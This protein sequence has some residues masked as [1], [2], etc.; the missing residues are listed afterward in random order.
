M[1]R[2]SKALFFVILF[3]AFLQVMIATV[4][5]PG[6]K[7]YGLRFFVLPLYRGELTIYNAF[8]SWVELFKEKSIL[9]EENRRL[10]EEIGRLQGE[11]VLLEEE[12]ERLKMEIEAE[13]IEQRFS[14]EVIPAQVIGRDPYDWFGKIV[15][16]RGKE[17]GVTSGLAVVTHQGMVGR[18]EVVYD[19]YAEVRMLLSPSFALGVLVQRTRDL[20]VLSGDGKGTCAVKYIPRDSQVAEGDVVITSGL[21]ESIPRG[22][23]V[24]KVS[25]VVERQGDLFKEVTVKPSCDFSRLGRVFVIR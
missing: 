18:V 24:G 21:G 9:L 7:V 22:I 20:G 5:L 19:K 11:K 14:F 16:D 4:H 12:I 2:K 15:I 8:R 25:G 13:R 10:R 3:F 6:R 17:D 23:V 1:S